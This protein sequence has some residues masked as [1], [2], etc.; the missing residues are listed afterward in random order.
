MELRRWAVFRVSGFYY[1]QSLTYQ[2]LLAACS[3]ADIRRFLYEKP[4]GRNR[5]QNNG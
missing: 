1:I 4:L 5:I 2:Y 3:S